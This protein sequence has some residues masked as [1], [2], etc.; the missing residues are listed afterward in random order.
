MGLLSSNGTRM[1]VYL[2]G[3]L[4]LSLMRN[5]GNPDVAFGMVGKIGFCS[6]VRRITAA[7]QVAC[8]SDAEDVFGITEG[9]K[10][11]A[12]AGAGGVRS[13]AVF[14]KVGEHLA[15]VKRA[16]VNILTLGGDDLQRHAVEGNA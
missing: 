16:V 10:I 14:L 7:R 3:Y 1:Q 2:W 6:H 12:R 9:L 8:N 13:A 5:P 4:Y 11:L 15:D